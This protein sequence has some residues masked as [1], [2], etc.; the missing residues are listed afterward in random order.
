[1]LPKTPL[2]KL[3]QGQ[4]KANQ[5]TIFHLNEVVE[6]KN[7]LI[8]K[9]EDANRKL[10]ALYD[11]QKALVRAHEQQIQALFEQMEKAQKEMM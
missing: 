8:E 11:E 2:L 4:K 3:K 6:S 9:T 10:E 1:M 7:K 5:Q